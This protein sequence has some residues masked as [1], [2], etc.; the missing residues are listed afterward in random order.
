ME[1]FNWKTYCGDISVKSLVKYSFLLDLNSIAIMTNA[2]EASV[3]DSIKIFLSIDCIRMI[4]CLLSEGIVSNEPS[5]SPV[6]M[7]G[8]SITPSFV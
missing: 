1:L 6:I 2:E 5:I 7:F 4:V 8:H 3:F